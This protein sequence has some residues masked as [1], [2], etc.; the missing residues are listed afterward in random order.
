MTPNNHEGQILAAIAEG[1][2]LIRV[3]G[4]G[5]FKLAPAFRQATQTALSAVPF[6]VIDMAAC[7]TLDSTFMGAIASVGLA[8]RKTPASHA[9]LINLS[10]STHA[11]LHGLG[12]DRI[13]RTLPPHALPENIGNLAGLAADLRPVDSA[14]TTTRE[15]AAMM[16]DAHETLTRVHPDNLRKFKDVLAFLKAEAEGT[17]PPKN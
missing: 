14:A 11:L 6:L 15:T 4:R 5:D 12:V 16:Y 7:T 3:D 17:T 2:A 1:C 13:I 9:V 8:T 10:P